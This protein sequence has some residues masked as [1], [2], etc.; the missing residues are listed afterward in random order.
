MRCEMNDFEV[1]TMQDG[2]DFR[3]ESGTVKCNISVVN[4]VQVSTLY[5]RFHSIF[6]PFSIFE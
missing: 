5:F 3:G 2:K 4:K 6:L 1:H